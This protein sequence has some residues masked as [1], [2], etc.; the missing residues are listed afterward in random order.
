MKNTTRFLRLLTL[1]CTVL[2]LFACALPCFAAT[3]KTEEWVEWELSD[4]G[5]RLTSGFD[6]YEYVPL[7][8][9][10]FIDPDTVYVYENQAN[11]YS[12]YSYKEQGDLTWLARGGYD[13]GTLYANSLAANGL[14][15]FLDGEEIGSYR[16]FE[17]Y[18]MA[19]TIDQ[20]EMQQLDALYADAANCEKL[21]VRDLADLDKWEIRAYDST[22]T[23]AYTHGMI[24]LLENGTYCYINYSTLDNSYFDAVGSFSYR[25]GQ[26]DAVYLKNTY[27]SRMENWMEDMTYLE[28]QFIYEYDPMADYNNS[29]SDSTST[30]PFWIIVILFG[31]VLPI[32]PLFVGFLMPR[33]EKRGYPK[34]WYALG[35]AAAVWLLLTLVFIISI[36]IL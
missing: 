18:N 33:S 22:G 8:M 34:Y 15:A 9:G 2:L 1:V 5:S 32:A 6:V 21:D 10:Y 20:N 12:V 3:E 30:V 17:D 14:E 24:Y 7:P 35:I 29:Y 31:L 4:D 11:I 26:V 36:L 23:V 28:V 27:L 16:L 19:H 25:K 13:N